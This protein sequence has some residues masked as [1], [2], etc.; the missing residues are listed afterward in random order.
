M[1]LST[2]MCGHMVIRSRMKTKILPSEDS[3]LLFEE[4]GRVRRRLI[5]QLLHLMIIVKESYELIL[6][7]QRL[8]VAS[9]KPVLD[10]RKKCGG[11]HGLAGREG[12]DTPADY[13]R[14]I[15]VLNFLKPC[16]PFLKSGFMKLLLGS[17]SE[18]PT[19]YMA[20]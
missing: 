14:V 9:V 16:F 4:E 12:R 10:F 1:R 18:S 15:A 19:S 5:L 8:T 6:E 20:W 13:R 2:R 11:S 17:Q 7:N 3:L